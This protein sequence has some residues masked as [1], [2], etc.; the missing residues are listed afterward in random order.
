MLFDD[1]KL[2]QN[3]VIR[4]SLLCEYYLY[5]PFRLGKN[6]NAV[7]QRM[8]ECRRMDDYCMAGKAVCETLR[9]IPYMNRKDMNYACFVFNLKKGGTKM[10]HFESIPSAT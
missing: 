2:H 9:M 1:Y 7:V 8:L 3:S 6:R 5:D 4:L 10:L